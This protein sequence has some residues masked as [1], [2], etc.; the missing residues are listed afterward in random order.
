MASVVDILL[1]VRA[2][3][4]GLNKATQGIKSFATTA[5]GALGVGAS[6]AGLTALGRAAINEGSRITD[7]AT[8][9]RL[10]NE[11]IQVF[12][13]AVKDAGASMEDFQA[14]TSRMQKSILETA[15]GLGGAGRHFR[16]LGLDAQELVQMPVAEQFE[17]IAQAVAKSDDPL[18]AYV[19][20]QGILG[21]SAF[22]LREVLQRLGTDG[23]GKLRED[24]DKTYGIM[25]DPAALDRA[26]DNIER[27]K[28]RIVVITGNIIGDMMS[29]TGRQKL[30]LQLILA[31]T[32]FS[33][34][35]LG[36]I[37]RV[38][39]FA[40]SIFSTTFKSLGESLGYYI[41]VAIEGGAKAIRELRLKV[42]EKNPLISQ[43][44]F[45]AMAREVDGA[46]QVGAQVV[47]GS[48]PTVSGFEGILGAALDDAKATTTTKF[49]AESQAELKSAIEELNKAR[50]EEIKLA[51][52]AN[53]I[54]QTTIGVTKNI[55]AEIDGLARSYQAQALAIQAQIT[56]LNASPFITQAEKNELTIILLGRQNDLIREQI[57][58]LNEKLLLEEDAATRQLIEQRIT[59]L[60]QQSSGIEGQQAGLQ[61][62]SA[63]GGIAAGAVDYMNQVGTLGEQLRATFVSI[64][65][66]ISQSVGGAI[67]GLIQGTM[68]WGQALR[69]IG[70]SIVQGIINSF[71]QMVA[72]WITAHIIMANIRRLFNMAEVT[73]NAAKNT[74]IVSQEAAA[75]AATATAWTPAAIVKSIATFGVAAIIGLAL[76]MAAI[77]AFDKGGYT[78]NGPAQQPAGIVHAGEWVAPQ[79][80][81]RDKMF[82]QVISNLEAARTGGGF[83]MGGFVE[84][85]F[86]IAAESGLPQNE[87]RWMRPII[88]RSM[89]LAE[90]L[91]NEPG[92]ESVIIDINQRNRDKLI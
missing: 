59:G 53:K 30:T 44:E 47:A 25:N 67:S 33:E 86:T 1:K 83:A 21:D 36:G 20:A 74:A 7:F 58:L 17:A 71:A 24:V 23:F 5:M 52:N 6:V 4:A 80:M 13:G 60:E 2:D 10:T 63:G 57:K 32:E 51:N 18:Q 48:R 3:L 55:R 56:A 27:L 38:A 75:G 85:Q 19:S 82:G 28:Q 22:K 8:K 92:V 46:N 65:Q 42:A 31:A 68:T 72:E 64:G 91:R 12:Q 11:E 29:E 14:A 34:Y 78:A 76:V 79:W 89:S 37:E 40:F 66:T 70:M 41:S 35:L 62:L 87:T 54:T 45:V 49:F 77:S 15:Q 43:E 90:E 26:A 73:E 39:R 61:P 69:N 50:A 81:V 88:V 16:A 84:P 9:L